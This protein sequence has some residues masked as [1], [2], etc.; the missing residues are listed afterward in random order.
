MRRALFKL[1]SWIG[2]T[3]A[4]GLV[5]IGLTGSLLV[6]SE[7]LDRA[8]HPALFRVTPQGEKL[9]LDTLLA[10]VRTAFPDHKINGLYL[11]E[12]DE[13]GA[14]LL[15][16][17]NRNGTYPQ[18]HLN[19][20]D[21]EVLAFRE[22][23][24]FHWLLKLHYS[25]FLND[26]GMALAFIFAVI[27]MLSSLTGI[28]LFRDWSAR[29]KRPVRWRQSARVVFSDLHRTIGAAA[30]VFNLVLGF[31]GA[32][33]N[34]DAFERILRDQPQPVRTY[35]PSPVTAAQALR[36]ADDALSGLRCTW[37]GFPRQEG[38]PFRVLGRVP[39][40]R[41]AIFGPYA[42]SV[43]LDPGTGAVREVRDIRTSGA[44]AKFEALIV[45][46]HFGNFGGWPVKVLY[47]FGGLA[48]AFLTVSGT[49]LWWRRTRHVSA[50]IS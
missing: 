20:Y 29:L 8:F 25:F 12:W 35:P 5:L 17:L 42:C 19:P 32:W 23:T 36:A 41:W 6:F 38:A 43:Q 15:V 3:G 49:V 7:E 47:I 50:P 44:R 30:L 22:C 1:H 27:L 46:L 16:S 45:P 24:F 39:G 34:W 11:S 2:L 4:L 37:L 9:P 26:L 48:P 31:T 28:V 10:R 14:A 33:L 40:A 13:P 21:G 18:A